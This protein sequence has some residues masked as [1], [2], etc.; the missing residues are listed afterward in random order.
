VSRSSEDEYKSIES[1]WC[2]KIY[3]AGDRA[4]KAFESNLSQ[5]LLDST[6]DIS[7]LEDCGLGLGFMF[8]VLY[9]LQSMDAVTICPRYQHP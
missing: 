1:S 4:L 9:M 7:N 5:T 6:S 3:F 8:P 2:R